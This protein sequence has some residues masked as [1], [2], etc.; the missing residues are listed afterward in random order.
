VRVRFF[1]FRR[2]T[3]FDRDHVRIRMTLTEFF[4]GP[5]VHAWVTR[6]DRSNA[7][8]T[9]LCLALQQVFVSGFGHSRAKAGVESP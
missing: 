2:H 1:F 4:L 7:R 3:D 8:F 5:G 9:G 6:A